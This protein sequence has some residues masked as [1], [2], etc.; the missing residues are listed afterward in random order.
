MEARRIGRAAAGVRDAARGL[1]SLPAEC[2]AIAVVVARCLRL[3]GAVKLIFRLR[4]S[5]RRRCSGGCPMSRSAPILRKA[6]ANSAEGIFA[7]TR[8][9]RFNAGVDL[10]A[11]S[12]R[13]TQRSDNQQGPDRQRRGARRRYAYSSW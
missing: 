7:E 6:F 12:S 11:V 10:G 8:Q 9:S 1:D 3:P 2:L 5:E 13:P 4:R